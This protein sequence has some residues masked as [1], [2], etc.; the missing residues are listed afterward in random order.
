MI[1]VTFFVHVGTKLNWSDF[2]LKGQGHELTT[3]SK[4][5]EAYALTAAHRVQNDMVMGNV[6]MLR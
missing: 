2:E 1:F 5:A 6:V 4:K 3:W